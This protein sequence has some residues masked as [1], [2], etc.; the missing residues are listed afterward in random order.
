MVPVLK[1][2]GLSPT[3]TR[4]RSNIFKDHFDQTPPYYRNGAFNCYSQARSSVG[5]GFFTAIVKPGKGY[6]PPPPPPAPEDSIKE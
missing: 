5:G 6:P 4:T 3:W 1:T 2:R